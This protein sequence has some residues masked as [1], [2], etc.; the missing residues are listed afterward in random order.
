MGALDENERDLVEQHIANDPRAA[1][2]LDQL[3]CH[4]DLLADG[5]DEAAP[6][7]G[8]AS[9]TCAVL[10]NP[11][12]FAEVLDTASPKDSNAPQPKQRD[13]FESIG[14]GRTAFTFMDMLVAVGACVAAVAIFFPALA[15][16]RL[17]ATRMQCE[18][19]LHQVSLAL[20]QFATNSPDHRYP[21]ISVEGPLSLAGSY[22]PKLMD[23]GLI[24]HA[25]TLQC[26]VNKNDL[27]TQPIPTIAQLENAPP[28]EVEKL[29]Q[30]L[31]SVYNYNMGGMVNGNLLAPAMR[32]LSNLPVSSDV[33]LWEDGKIVPQGHAD[34]RANI[35]FDDGHVEYLAVE[36]IPTSLRQY[37]LNDKGEVAAGVNEDDA[38]VANGM[39]HPIHLSH[40]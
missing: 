26:A 25:D 19:N 24:Q 39:A 27:N 29:Q 33:V 11:H 18:N 36:D 32:G 17:L 10:D 8:L 9:R 35:L 21:G 38:V 20:Q 14:G 22:A 13:A 37:F 3:R 40:Q 1:D 28:E 34:G 15:S 4:L 2:E 6:P 5:L 30:S 16:S 31:S 23:A 12:L 7:V